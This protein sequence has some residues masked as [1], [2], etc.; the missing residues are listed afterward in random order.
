MMLEEVDAELI[1]H[2]VTPKTAGAPLGQV[3]D[4]SIVLLAARMPFHIMCKRSLWILDLS[5]DTDTTNQLQ[6]EEH[7]KASLMLLGRTFDI[8]VGLLLMPA[9]GGACKRIGKFSCRKRY[10]T[11]DAVTPW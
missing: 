8:L 6:E 1:E 4:G 9:G 5:L 7:E 10:E 2:S 11:G 3:K